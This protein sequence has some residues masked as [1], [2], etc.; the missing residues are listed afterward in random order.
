M[1]SDGPVGEG[2]T[3][4]YVIDTLLPYTGSYFSVQ[5]IHF[6]I[7]YKRRLQYVQTSAWASCSVGWLKQTSRIRQFLAD[8]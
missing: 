1:C 7:P 3:A 8:G 6:G 5:K 4:D 2:L